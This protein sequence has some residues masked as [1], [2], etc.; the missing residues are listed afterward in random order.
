MCEIGAFTPEDM[1]KY[2][3]YWDAIRRKK[4]SKEAALAE[5]EAIGLEKGKVE[6]KIDTVINCD[7]AGIPIETISTITGLTIEHIK[8]ILE[9]HKNT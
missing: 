5:G 2:D 8:I 7:K 1:A 6:E 4:A 9:T 3:G